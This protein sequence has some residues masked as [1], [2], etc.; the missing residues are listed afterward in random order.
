MEFLS[1]F[2][3]V[4]FLFLAVSLTARIIYLRKNG[5]KVS[6]NQKEKPRYL[7]F[8]YLVFGLL[9]FIWLAELA[10]L[11]FQFSLSVLPEF[12]TKSLLHSQFLRYAGVFVILISLVFWMLTLLHFRFSLRF[13]LDE[14]NQ[15]KLI[16]G[17]V[18]SHSRNPFFLSID[19]FFTGLALFH[20]SIFFLGMGFLTL[21]SI[22]FF[23]LKEE[24]FLRKHYGDV[25]KKYQE[26]TGRYF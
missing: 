9:F 1:T 16:T 7:W 18:F 15:G 5:I 25:Y 12:L 17:G 14:K 22:H 24:K 23:I 6:S 8:L 11:A 13:G 3:F 4:G 26:K 20:P 19:L 10:S 2:P 21:V